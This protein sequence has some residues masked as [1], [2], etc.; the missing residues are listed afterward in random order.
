MARDEAWADAEELM[1]GIAGRIYDHVGLNSELIIVEG[2]EKESLLDLLQNDDEIFALIL[3]AKAGGNPGPLVEYF[4]GEISG[5]LPC[6]VVIVPGN[7]APDRI[8]TMV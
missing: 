3:G 8:D 5:T 7:L 1:T 4:S 6:P 2:D